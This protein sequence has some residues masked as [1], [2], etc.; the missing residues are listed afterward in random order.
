MTVTDLT[1][2]NSSGAGLDDMSIERRPAYR[3][4]TDYLLQILPTMS[5]GDPL[6]TIAE[7]G[8]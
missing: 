3:R 7:L 6:P 1:T 8:E 2:Y 5:V 4:I